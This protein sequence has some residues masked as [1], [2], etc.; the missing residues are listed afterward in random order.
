MSLTGCE[1]G[2]E[3]H[4]PEEVSIGESNTL[5]LEPAEDS[6]EFRGPNNTFGDLGVGAENVDSR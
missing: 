6:D 5:R 4:E 1:W 2:G 3:M